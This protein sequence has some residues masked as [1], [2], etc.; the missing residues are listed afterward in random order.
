MMRQLAMIPGQSS[1]VAHVAAEDISDKKGTSGGKGREPGVKPE[2]PDPPEKP[3][4]KEAAVGSKAH[5]VEF[6]EDGKH[7]LFGPKSKGDERDI[8]PIKAFDEAVEKLLAPK[9]PKHKPCIAVWGSTHPTPWVTCGCPSGRTTL[10]RASRA[11]FRR[12]LSRRR[13]WVRAARAR[14]LRLSP[15]PPPR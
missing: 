11:F 10:I 3:E 14:C 2:K 9:K 13:C 8:L 4:K 7:V 1:V 15:T 6:H 5:L 12:C